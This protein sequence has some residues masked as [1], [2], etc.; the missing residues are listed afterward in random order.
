[1]ICQGLVF[2]KEHD[3]EAAFLEVKAANQHT[4]DLYYRLGYQLIDETRLYVLEL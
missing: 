4:L 2:L 1:M 3:R